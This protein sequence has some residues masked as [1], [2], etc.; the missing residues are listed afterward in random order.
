MDCIILNNILRN[1]FTGSLD[2]I[3]YYSDCGYMDG[4]EN[5]SF[6]LK[7]DGKRGEKLGGGARLPGR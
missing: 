6:L 4:L 1:I 3:C 2:C 7:V 5:F